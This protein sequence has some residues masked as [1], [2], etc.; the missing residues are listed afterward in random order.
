MDQRTR[1]AP[2]L[3]PLPPEHTPELKEQFETFRKRMGFIPNSI[4]IMQRRPEMVRAFT[5]MTAVIWS[6]SSSVPRPC[7]EAVELECVRNHEESWR[8]S[9][10]FSN[11]VQTLAF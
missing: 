10:L 7:Y 9:G 6:P 3:V 2:R 11:F 8:L 4:L 5:Q 1:P